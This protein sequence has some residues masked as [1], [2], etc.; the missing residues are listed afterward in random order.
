MKVKDVMHKGVAWAAPAQS[1]S[2]IANMMRKEDVGAIPVGD[3][4]RLIG[5]VTDRDIVLRG[6]A[7]GTDSQKLSARDVMSEPITYCLE[8]EDI[9]DAVRLME[10]KQIRRLPVIN[11]Q[12]RMVGMVS[13]GDIAAKAGPALCSETMRAVSAHH[14]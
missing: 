12:K 3:N 5:M 9:E 8:D 10:N 14:D 2:E 1:V 4:D 13:I 11:K 7:N 6:L